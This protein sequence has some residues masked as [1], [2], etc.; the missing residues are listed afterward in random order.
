MRSARSLQHEPAGTQYNRHTKLDDFAQVLN[1][2]VDGSLSTSVAESAL[3]EL[4]EGVDDELIVKDFDF[5][6]SVYGDG[7]NGG[8]KAGGVGR[9]DGGGGGGGGVGGGGRGGRGARALSFV[10]V[11]GVKEEE[12]EEEAAP[13]AVFVRACVH[14]YV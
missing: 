13:A 8:G 7:G 5:L 2:Y 1:D 4:L 3:R 10:G 11:G 14:H 9:G 12:E 6:V